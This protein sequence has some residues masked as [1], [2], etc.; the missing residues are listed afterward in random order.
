MMVRLGASSVPCWAYLCSPGLVNLLCILLRP[1]TNKYHLDLRRPTFGQ[2]PLL[3]SRIGGLKIGTRIMADPDNQLQGGAHNPDNNRKLKAQLEASSAHLADWKAT[4][5][6]KLK[7]LAD[8]NARLQ[9]FKNQDDIGK[10]GSEPERTKQSPKEPS[11][12]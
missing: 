11:N 2:L 4:Q 10:E 3:P 6:R 1:A 9:A 8:L 7:Q 5:A 12:K